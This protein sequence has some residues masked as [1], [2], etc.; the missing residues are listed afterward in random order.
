MFI[1]LIDYEI[2]RIITAAANVANCSNG[3][4]SGHYV[5]CFALPLSSVTKLRFLIYILAGAGLVE[6]VLITSADNNI[7]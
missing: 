1:L 5:I 4:F 7:K 3:F 2:F 6:L